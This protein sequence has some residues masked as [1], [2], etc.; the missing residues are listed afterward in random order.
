[1]L[2]ISCTNPRKFQ[3]GKPFVYKTN[4]NVNG[5]SGA[6]KKRLTERL[7][8][9]LDDSLKTRIVSYAGVYRTLYKP[10]A[11][12]TFNISRSRTFMRALL[13]AQGY[14]YPVITDTFRIDTVG[15]QQRVTVHFHIQ[16]GKV[17][18]LDSIGY[19]LAS[20]NLQ[21]L[22]MENRSKST[23][24]KSDP[25]TLET[26][27]AEL[28]R[29]LII[30]RDNGYYKLSK[31]DLYCEPDTVVAALIDP[32]LDPFEQIRL[33][34]SLRKKR[35]NPTIN[36]TFKQRKVKDSTHL[37][38]FYMGRIRVYPDL[39]MVE[40][41]TEN[42][43][44][45]TVL[46]GYQFI[47]NSDKFKLP[48]LAKRVALKQGDLYRQSNYFKTINTFN[49]LGPWQNVDL[50]LAE[51]YDSVPTLNAALRL[52][53]AKKIYTTLDLEASRN[54]T[55]IITTGQLFGVGV[56]ARILNR[57][58]YREAIQ[59]STNGRF[60]IELGTNIIQTLQGS[61]AHNISFPRF[62]APKPILRLFKVDESSLTAPRTFL[63]INASYTNRRDFFK[64]RSFNA[65]YGYEWSTK[66]RITWQYIPFN[67]EFTNVI[68]TDS[69][70]RLEER[71]PS[72]KFAFNDGLIISQ[73]VSLSTG[74][75][76]GNRLS[77][78]RTRL[79]ESGAI[80]GLIKKL[81]LG[82][83]RRFI[84]L[85]GEYKYYINE[86]RSQ[87]AFRAYAGYGFV[88]GKTDTGSGKI[89]RENT[90]PFFKA[91]YAG[92]PYSMRA[93]QI[94]K[95]GPGSDS[96]YDPK[97]STSIDRFGNMQLEFNTEFRFNITTIAGIKVNSALFVDI[98]NIWGKEFDT[99]GKQIDDASFKLGRLYK[100]LAV[101]A[102]TSL[103]F[104]FEF[105]MIRL[106][107]AYQL[108]NPRYSY[109]NGG[110]FHDLRLFD[111]QFQLG[112][113]APF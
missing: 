78:F 99:N 62:I 70:R 31:E 90:L 8:N 38:Q 51:H 95:L 75:E 15:K 76:H 105:F 80:F 4:I 103:R 69:L 11:F 30:F 10:P 112:I 36:I 66:R 107:W 17:F 41:S 7:Q 91:F 39:F 88:Y 55:D 60:G 77:L 81:E 111:G 104:D 96:L 63:N 83:L 71:I 12:D 86:K 72:Y 44:D 50:R 42:E 73:V 33:L 87:W 84:K 93:W 40:D 106:D 29:L 89:V 57:N 97:D 52:Y 101:G 37:M 35:E 102:G 67:F 43:R 46:G 108:K 23:L 6:E 53:P 14:F 64:V 65:A 24:K 18:R 32:T 28:D 110:W 59:T 54:T 68:K 16:P 48:F 109:L 3:A 1:M 85:D 98:G 22:A 47:Y 25:Y 5:V 92:G 82:D 113:G 100:D 20:P 13:N 26:I 94:R 56:N 58:A 27:S 45:T 2:V 19:A 61:L 9:Q 34:D 74:R 79:E 21:Q 49:Q